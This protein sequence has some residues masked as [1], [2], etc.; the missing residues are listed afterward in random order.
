[1]KQQEGQIDI[2]VAQTI[3]LADLILT[4]PLL[5]HLR[6]AFPDA[7]IDVLVSK[8]MESLLA[9]HPAVST[10]ITFDKHE[11]DKGW[12]G[13]LRVAHRLQG[14]VEIKLESGTKL[15]DLR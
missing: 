11:E 8:G 6:Y 14:R 12:K 3:F 5:Q 1:L 4:I 10:V 7:Q 13:I 9:F 2:V 15:T